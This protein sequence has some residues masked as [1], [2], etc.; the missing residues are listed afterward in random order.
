MKMRCS[1]ENK[2]AKHPLRIG[3]ITESYVMGGVE[4]FTSSL[5]NHLDKDEYEVVLICRDLSLLTP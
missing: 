4:R 2:N 5:I 3:Y 1:E